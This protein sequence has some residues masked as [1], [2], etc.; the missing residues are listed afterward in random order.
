MRCVPLLAIAVM[1]AAC[2]GTAGAAPPAHGQLLQLVT[3][4]TEL[5]ASQSSNWFGYNQGMIEQGGK[6]FHSVAGEW[7]V[8]AASQHTAGQSEASADWVGIGGGCVDSSCAVGD[9]TL[10]QV[11]TEQDVDASGHPSYSAWYELVPAPSSTISNM[12]VHPGDRMQASVT[13]TPQGSEMWTIVI[14]DLTR[15][16]SFSTRLPYTSTYATAEWI[17]ETPVVIDRTGAGIAALP[18]LG[19]IPFDFAATNGARA[20]LVAAEQVQLTDQNS[21]VIGAPST[22][23]AESDGFALCAWSSTCSPPATAAGA[24]PQIGGSSPSSHAVSQHHPACRVP[25][26]KGMRLARAKAALRRAHCRLGTVRHRH[27]HGKRAG[28]VLSQSVKAGRSLR[29]WSRISVT[30][31]R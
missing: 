29:V 25:R 5:H 19:T 8:P 20:N 21:N 27:R 4:Q 9:N 18:N 30:V 7:T 13:E 23:D 31:E 1:L 10:I 12:A 17:E 2:T 6:Q 26:L 11:G 28:T 24:Q 22:P 15:G 14:K 3:P 16:E